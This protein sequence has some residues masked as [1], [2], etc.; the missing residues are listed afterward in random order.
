M[1]PHNTSYVCVI[2][3]GLGRDTF[4]MFCFI[5]EN[6]MYL[7]LSLSLSLSTF[8]THRWL[9]AHEKMILDWNYFLKRQTS[10]NNFSVLH[11]F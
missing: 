4:F 11:S 7:S 8:A 10:L 6:D 3:W 1:G 9:K 5:L 2:V